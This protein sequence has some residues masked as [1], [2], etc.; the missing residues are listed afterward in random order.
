M[1]TTEGTLHN[2][3]SSFIQAH[4]I[5]L[6]KGVVVGFSGG[7][8]SLALLSLLSSIAPANCV[9]AVY[10]NHNLREEGELEREIALNRHNCQLLQVPL[11]IR[12]A[13]VGQIDQIG[14]KRKGGG[15]EAARYF[16]YQELEEVR[17]SLSF[18]YIATAHNEDD[19]NETL[20][21]RLFQGSR[22]HFSQP[23]KEVQEN[24]IRP[25]LHIKREEIE[26]Y[27]RESGFSWSSDS[28]N[29]N[30]KFLRNKIRHSLIPSLESIFPQWTKGLYRLSDE[31]QEIEQTFEGEAKEYIDQYCVIDSKENRVLLDLEKLVSLSSPLIRRVL[32]LAFNRLN[33]GSPLRLPE[34]S[35]NQ[36]IL[37]IEGKVERKRIDVINSSVTFN[38]NAL[39]WEKTAR[40]LGA[41]YISLVYSEYTY[42]CEE[43]YLHKIALKPN[44]KGQ[45]GQIWIPDDVIKGALIVRSYNQYDT[46]CLRQGTKKVSSLLSEWGIESRTRWKVPVLVDD[47]GVLAILGK[48]FLGNNRVA[49]RAL[50][51]P[52]APKETTLYSVLII[53]G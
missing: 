26:N 5:D 6:S 47:N 15:E 53:E 7:A 51:S 8:D 22:L 16:R 46:I 29:T 9:Q 40:T 11:I 27:L 32:Y 18:A 17:S 25:L 2:R 4:S 34:K 31:L 30:E 44:E 33:H 24:K 21:M 23:I 14:E 12:T 38:K 13:N 52:L 20:L 3:I 39:I 42:L 50:V 35:V 19:Q 28:T 49:K 41:A 37:A 36:I 1:S 48:V 43:Y 45:K 10:V